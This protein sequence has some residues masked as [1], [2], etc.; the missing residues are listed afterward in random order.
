[1]IKAIIFILFTT[2]L[3][4]ANSASVLSSMLAWD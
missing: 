4:Y 3:V 1:M 2:L